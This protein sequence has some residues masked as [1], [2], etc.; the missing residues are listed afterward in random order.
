MDATSLTRSAEAV[1]SRTPKEG[2]PTFQQVVT[3]A[4]AKAEMSLSGL[5]EIRCNDERWD[6]ADSD[7]DFAVSLAR[8]HVQRMMATEYPDY[9]TFAAE[10]LQVASAV[11][12]GKRLFSR[13]DCWY[14]RRLHTVCGMFEQA[15]SM[16]EFVAVA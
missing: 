13:Q 2:L 4:L 14:A 7:I 6:D 10:W 15:R 11:N 1:G 9:D 12:L 8:A 16:V 3:L 5:K